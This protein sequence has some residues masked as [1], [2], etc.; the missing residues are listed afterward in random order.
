M[1]YLVLWAA[2]KL[3]SLRLNKLRLAL[4]ALFGTIYAIMV[5]FPQFSLI[6]SLAIKIL[7]SVLMLVIA[8]VPCSGRA[9]LRVFLYL[10]IVS[11]AMGGSVIALLYFTS[12]V[13]G[14]LQ[15]YNGALV[16]LG[17]VHYGWLTVGIT[18]AILLGYGGV[19]FLRK[20]SLKKT[21]VYRIRIALNSKSVEVKALLDTGNQLNEPLTKKPVI[22]IEADALKSLLP[23]GIIE[24]VCGK[25]GTNIFQFTERLSEDWVLRFRWIP[26]HSVGKSGSIWGIIPDALEI[27][28]GEKV[29]RYNH[30]V[31]GLLPKKINREGEYQALLHPA[32]LGLEN[33]A[34]EDK[35]AAS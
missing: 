31:L 11:F 1:D 30:V 13:P 26:Y 12:S 28:D 21:L 29:K 33:L 25:E 19:V 34:E 8:F 35:D 22:V 5:F 27:I 16:I 20:A 10:Y 2:G 14:Y 32:L 6:T 23:Q 7:C 17:G 4:G 18:M 3:A 24:A 9:F 15:I